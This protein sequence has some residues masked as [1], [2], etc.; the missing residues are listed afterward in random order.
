MPRNSRV[1]HRT[2]ANRLPR[3]ASLFEEQLI[4]KIV[5]ENP[6]IRDFTCHFLFSEA[7]ARKQCY[8]MA[9][10]KVSRIRK[11][12]RHRTSKWKTAKWA[13]SDGKMTMWEDQSHC[14]ILFT[15]P[16]IFS[17]TF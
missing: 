11:D 7:C 12:T 5:D 3:E 17:P 2:P 15:N 13:S 9:K 10:V 4:Q 16:T 14:C 8:L 1:L 6:R